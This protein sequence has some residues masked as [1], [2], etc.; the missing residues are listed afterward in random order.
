MT[1]P[2]DI[3][4]PTITAVLEEFLREEAA[5]L[6]PATQIKYRDIVELLTDSINGYAYQYLNES[7]SEKFDRLYNGE[8][9]EFCDIFGPEHIIPNLDEFLSY[10]M[11][12]KV[13][14]GKETLR[15][16]GTV[17]KKL[18]AWLQRKGYISP[19]AGKT[20]ADKA[21]KA[22][23]LLPKA[24]ECAQALQEFADEQAVGMMDGITF[25]HFTITR[26]EPGK[27]WLES[28]ISDLSLG[29][30]SVPKTVSSKCEPGWTVSLGLSKKRGKWIIVEVGNVYPL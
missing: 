15:A 20:A 26:V 10:F 11:V 30:L 27:L 29:P 28:M 22:A 23:K 18:A 6:S 12:H 3:A 8:N 17:T 14:A 16:A 2:N 5:D 9:V 21:S 1:K 19:A 4:E 24:E 7:D 25:D 13:I